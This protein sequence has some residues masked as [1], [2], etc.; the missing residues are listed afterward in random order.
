[1]RLNPIGFPKLPDAWYWLEEI[2]EKHFRFEKN[3]INEIYNL[4]YIFYIIIIFK[5]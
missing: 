4:Y 1:M 3:I 5:K 2:A